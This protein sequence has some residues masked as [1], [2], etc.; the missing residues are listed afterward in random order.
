MDYSKF[1]ERYIDGIMS[2]SEKTW[3]EKELEGNNVLQ[4]DLEL[5]QKTNRVILE[6]EILDL[7]TQLDD[8]HKILQEERDQKHRIKPKIFARRV[9]LYASGIAASV[10]IAVLITMNIDRSY[11][12]EEVY[13]MFYE[14]Y[15]SNI[16][17][18]SSEADIDNELYHAMQLYES[19][20]YGAA[21]VLFERVL[22][23]DPERQG[24]NLYSGISHM[25][26]E[27][28]NEANKKFNKVIEQETIYKES[29][30][31]Y[32]GFCYLMTDEKE[33]AIET[34]EDIASSE[35]FYSRDAKKVLR[36]LK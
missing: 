4:Q 15:E 13:S 32:L 17:F 21:I 29:A 12:N 25:E 3:F 7:K 26:I 33:K 9:L 19:K 35:G 30:E 2:D 28:Y 20:N 27:Q 24:V 23:Q 22:E 5:Y 6:K 36:K 16:T 31:W 8:I 34:Y 11:S 1:I 18:R 10:I 14:P